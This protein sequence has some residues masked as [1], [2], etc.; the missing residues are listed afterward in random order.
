MHT[1][2]KT[3]K[4]YTT[5]LFFLLEIF[6]NQKL[7]NITVVKVT[8]LDQYTLFLFKIKP[9]EHLRFSIS[10]QNRTFHKPQNKHYYRTSNRCLTKKIYNKFETIGETISEKTNFLRKSVLE[11]SISNFNPTKGSQMLPNHRIF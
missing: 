6:S 4:S 2:P 7:C 10:F 8:Y 3:S 11:D 9:S 5:P 1:T